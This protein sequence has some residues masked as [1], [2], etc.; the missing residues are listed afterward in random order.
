MNSNANSK[1]ARRPSER[2]RILIIINATFILHVCHKGR[3]SHL[4]VS[5]SLKVDLIFFL[6]IRLLMQRIRVVLLIRTRDRSIVGH[7][8][9]IILN[10]TNFTV[11]DIVRRHTAMVEII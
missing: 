7:Y 4:A 9:I 3:K 5:V 6:F 2:H 8:N 10:V 1:D 11:F